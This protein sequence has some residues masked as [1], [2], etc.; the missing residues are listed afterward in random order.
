MD[1][2]NL[3]RKVFADF[4]EENKNE[5]NEKTLR[6]NWVKYRN[7]KFKLKTVKMF[8][9]VT[10]YLKLNAAIKEAKNDPEEKINA[11]A[12]PVKNFTLVNIILSELINEKLFFFLE[13][14]QKIVDENVL[15]QNWNQFKAENPGILHDFACELPLFEIT[16]DNALNKTIKGDKKAHGAKGGAGHFAL[17]TP[18]NLTLPTMII[19]D[20]ICDKTNPFIVD[21]RGNTFAHLIP[22]SSNNATQISKLLDVLLKNDPMILTKQNHAGFCPLHIAV[23]LGNSCA[24]EIFLNKNGNVN[25]KTAEG[26]NPLACVQAYHK[27]GKLIVA[28]HGVQDYEETILLLLKAHANPDDYNSHKVSP[29]DRL[30]LSSLASIKKNPF[31]K[32]S[33]WIKTNGIEKFQRKPEKVNDK[34]SVDS[35]A[36]SKSVEKPSESAASSSPEDAKQLSVVGSS[37]VEVSKEVVNPIDDVVPAFNNS[38][39]YQPAPSVPFQS[40]FSDLFSKLSLSS[41]NSSPAPLAEIRMSTAASAEVDFTDLASPLTFSFIKPA[42]RHSAPLPLDLK[43]SFP[44]PPSEDYSRPILNQELPPIHSPESVNPDKVLMGPTTTKQPERKRG[45][46]AEPI[47]LPDELPPEVAPAAATPKNIPIS[48]RATFFGDSGPYDRLDSEQSL[49]RVGH[50]LPISKVKEHSQTFFNK[51]SNETKNIAHP[52]PPKFSSQH[53]LAAELTFLQQLG[54]PCNIQE[55]KEFT[56]SIS[57][58]PD[59]QLSAMID[60]IRSKTKAV[61]FDKEQKFYVNFRVLAQELQEEINLEPSPADMAKFNLNPKDGSFIYRYTDNQQ[62]IAAVS[63]DGSVVMY[64][65]V[66]VK[67]TFTSEGLKFEAKNMEHLADIRDYLAKN[68]ITIIEQKDAKRESSNASYK[69]IV[70]INPTDK[71]PTDPIAAKIFNLIAVKDSLAMSE[72][73]AAISNLCFRAKIITL[74]ELSWAEDWN[75]QNPRYIQKPVAAVKTMPQ[76]PIRLERTKSA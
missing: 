52:I 45:N 41:F 58:Y 24:A 15:Q 37:S 2:R 20:I 13:D 66:N 68:G 21:S 73:A 60:N 23:I 3:I 55:M 29:K 51:N 26:L 5:V 11:A 35:P 8:Y 42:P 63:S 72:K 22:E 33:T 17:A 14:N 44:N 47:Q 43:E 49:P 59:D 40:N 46:Y 27:G 36:D 30:S 65:L 54:L 12:S 28:R 61:V 10:P 39:Q 31:K 67:T 32:L 48:K 64:N 69:I 56:L 50:S 25:L 76:N 6:I 53:A 16:L 19:S 1:T 34:S 9:K 75:K 4:I 70:K 18:I 38:N 74:A 62:N 7:D 71:P 57:D